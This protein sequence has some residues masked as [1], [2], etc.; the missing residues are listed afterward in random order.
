MDRLKKEQLVV[1]GMFV[2]YCGLAASVVAFI[3][4]LFNR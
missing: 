4:F 1:T 2:M 3:L